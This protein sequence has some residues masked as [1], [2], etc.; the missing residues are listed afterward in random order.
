MRG[1]WWGAVGGFTVGAVCASVLGVRLTG[2]PSPVAAVVPPTE[3][4]APGI[5]A[6]AGDEHGVTD[7]RARHKEPA[8]RDDVMEPVDA[9]HATLPAR[10]IPLDDPR[11]WLGGGL[12]LPMAERDVTDA[13]QSEATRASAQGVIDQYLREGEAIGRRALPLDGLQWLQGGPPGAD[14][15]VIVLVFMGIGEPFTRTMVPELAAR[16]R[17]LHDPNIAIVGLASA[18]KSQFVDLGPNAVKWLDTHGITFPVAVRTDAFT[19][20]YGIERLPVVVVSVHGVTL[21]RLHPGQLTTT[22]LKR[23]QA[24]ARDPQLLSD[25]AAR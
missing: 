23:L 25:V 18:W 9:A 20:W 13:T 21:W 12:S 14:T 2:A 10:L 5:Q 19:S 15:P 11:I 1:L 6:E 7:A 24:L 4:L 22:E 3:A 16:V 17:A 8:G